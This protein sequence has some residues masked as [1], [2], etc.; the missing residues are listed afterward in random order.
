MD[1]DML[2]DNFKN[3]MYRTIYYELIGKT[4]GYNVIV[5]TYLGIPKTKSQTAFEYAERVIGQ[6]DLPGLTI[7]GYTHL[8]EESRYSDHEITQ[9]QYGQAMQYFA[10]IYHRI[11]GGKIQLG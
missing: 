11:T 6:N 7:M 2:N 1:K 4:F 3:S 10:E 9:D 5:S 8:Y